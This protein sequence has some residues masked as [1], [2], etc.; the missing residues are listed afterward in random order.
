MIMMK[1]ALLLVLRVVATQATF[2]FSYN[3][4]MDCGY[5]FAVFDITDLTC[6]P[7][8]STAIYVDSNVQ[9][10]DVSSDVCQFGDYMDVQGTVTTDINVY[11][12]FDVTL[13]ACFH[14]EG[15]NSWVGCST[16]TSHIDILANMA[17]NEGQNNNDQQAAQYSTSDYA[18]AGDHSFSAR[19]QVP[20][21]SFKF[22][23][24]TCAV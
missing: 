8:S 16:Y 6:E 23:D 5:P 7:S 11:R 14:T 4:D 12:Y 17:V 24:G 3:D 10:A 1:L 15:S 21:R 18:M 19:L 13:K 2:S 20:S 22:Y 9:A